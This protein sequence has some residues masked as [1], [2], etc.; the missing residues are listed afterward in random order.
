VGERFDT[1]LLAY[2][3]GQLVRASDSLYAQLAPVGRYLPAD[4]EIG[5]GV[6]AR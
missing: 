3:G 1:P 4:V 6:E 5:T 2:R